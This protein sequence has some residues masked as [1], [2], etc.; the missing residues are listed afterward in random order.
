MKHIDIYSQKLGFDSTVV[1]GAWWICRHDAVEAGVV[2]KRHSRA[3]FGVAH[4]LVE[5]GCGRVISAAA[6]WRPRVAHLLNVHLSV[7]MKKPCYVEI[8]HVHC[9][10][11]CQNKS[12]PQG[13]TKIKTVK[14]EAFYSEISHNNRHSLSLL[15]LGIWVRGGGLKR[16]SELSKSTTPGNA[17]SKVPCTREGYVS[18]LGYVS[19]TQTRCTPSYDSQGKTEAV[20]NIQPK[21]ISWNQ[22]ANDFFCE[23]F[24]TFKTNFASRAY[25]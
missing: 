11:R 1:K 8:I 25:V 4:K 24:S 20:L 17:E 13:T 6:V 9:I 21:E 10:S 18:D 5:H 22:G 12:W 3:R 15:H 23:F 14:I 2:L 16:T 19:K 7:W